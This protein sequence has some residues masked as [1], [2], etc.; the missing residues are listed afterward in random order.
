MV[1]LAL[2]FYSVESFPEFLIHPLGLFGERGNDSVV[3][4][5]LGSSGVYRKMDL[6]KEGVRAASEAH[7]TFRMIRGRGITGERSLYEDERFEVAEETVSR[8][9]GIIGESGNQDLVCDTHLIFGFI[10]RSRRETERAIY[11][12][13]EAL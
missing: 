13:E 2:L 4:G 1:S 12:F 6:S 5:M 8:T 9:A 3:T 11:H 10:C 7:A